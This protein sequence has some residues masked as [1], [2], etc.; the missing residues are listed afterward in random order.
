MLSIEIQK[1][2]GGNLN[3]LNAIPAIDIMIKF[4]NI[5]DALDKLIV[6]VL[7]F[8]SSSFF[9]AILADFETAMRVSSIP[10]PTASSRR[11]L[12]GAIISDK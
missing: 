9:E 11:V 7:S 4:L 10:A 5:I 12:L 3:S 1:N 6:A 8:A 2:N